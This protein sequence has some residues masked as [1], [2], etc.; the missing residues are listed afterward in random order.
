MKNSIIF[1]ITWFALYMIGIVMY[2]ANAFWWLW[3][4]YGFLALLLLFVHLEILD[5]NAG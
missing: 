3:L 5:D 2:F 4:L 1:P